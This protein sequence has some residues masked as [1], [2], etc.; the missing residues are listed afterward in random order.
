M[1]DEWWDQ[2]AVAFALGNAA[3][4]EYIAAVSPS[5]LLGLLD[6]LEAAR[7]LLR[8]V[9]HAPGRSRD[10]EIECMYCLRIFEPPVHQH[11]DDCFVLRARAFLGDS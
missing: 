1:S 4:A 2:G 9:E 7:E 8:E 10:G 3:D 6:E 5:V 11:D